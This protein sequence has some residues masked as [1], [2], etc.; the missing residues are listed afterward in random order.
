[1]RMHLRLVEIRNEIEMLENPVLRKIYEDI[2][3][4]AKV[5]KNTKNASVDQKPSVYIVTKKATLQKQME[6]LEVA[7]TLIGSDEVVNMLPS[8]KVRFYLIKCAIERIILMTI[9]FLCL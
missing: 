9:I 4:N 1:M 5:I 2:N 3:F 7:K 8:L 6:Y